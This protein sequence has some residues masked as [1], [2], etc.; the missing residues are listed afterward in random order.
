[1]L[2]VPRASRKHRRRPVVSVP[3]MLPGPAPLSRLYLSPSQATTLSQDQGESLGFMF[4]TLWALHIICLQ[5]WTGIAFQETSLFALGLTIQ[6]GHRDGSMCSNPTAARRDF[7]VFHINGRHTVSLSFCACDRAGT[8][9]SFVQQLLRFE[10]YPATHYEPHTA[11][12][13]RLLEHYHIQSLQGK[14]SMFDY[15]ESLDRLTDNTGTKIL[16]TRY[17]EFMRVVSQWR[18]LKALKRAGRGHHLKGAAGTM[19]G[20]LAIL[21]PACPRPHVNLPD[22]WNTVSDDLK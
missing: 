4:M 15:Y 2:R 14:V 13:F 20:E 8:S 17:R 10:L 16:N 5:K 21:C 1:M 12:S 19:G 7:S 9:G 6:L 18:H 3:R 11:F 22:N